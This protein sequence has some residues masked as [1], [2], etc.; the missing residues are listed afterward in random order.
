MH[1]CMM[2]SRGAEPSYLLGIE[3]AFAPPPM[4]AGGSDAAC[5]KP[6]WGKTFS[7]G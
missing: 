2:H 4:G 5:W 3:D 1:A 7:N 6:A